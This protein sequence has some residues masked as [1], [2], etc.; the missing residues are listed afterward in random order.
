MKD[1]NLKNYYVPYL[2]ATAL[3]GWAVP[4]G[5]YF[6]T[7]ET[8]RGWITLVTI[9]VTFVTGLYVGSLGVA[10]PV[11]GYWW[12]IAQVFASPVVFLIGEQ[13]AAGGYPVYGKPAE[14]G[15]IYT[16]IAGMLNLLCIVKEVHT[17]HIINKQGKED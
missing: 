5:G 12:Y 16:S 1:N 8:R 11:G 15:Q 7:G 9:T 2:S 6:L 14:I 17:A 13:T 4:G 10:D 3:A